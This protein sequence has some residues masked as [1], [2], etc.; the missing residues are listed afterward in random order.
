M[1]EMPQSRSAAS[2]RQADAPRLA[3][4]DA[5]SVSAQMQ[6]FD[7]RRSELRN[8]LVSLTVRRDLLTQQLRNA[9]PAGQAQLQAQLKD[10]GARTARLN[11]QLNAIDDAADK[12]LSSSQG[13]AAPAVPAIPAIPAMPAFPA[14]GGRG[15]TVFPGGDAHVSQ[16]VARSM[17]LDGAGFGLL[18]L[19]LFVWTRRPRRSRLAPED[20]ARM[21]QLQHAVDVIAVEVERISESQRYM[22]KLLNDNRGIDAGAAQRVEAKVRDRA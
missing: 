8:Q 19:A 14:M 2:S 12:V 11:L 18:L 5:Q 7:A 4:D 15:I 6:M 16:M 22:S 10:I 9:D 21:D 17:I 20:T 13:D 3:G 1:S